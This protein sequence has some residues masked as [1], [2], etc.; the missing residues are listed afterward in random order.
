MWMG[1]RLPPIIRMTIGL[2]QAQLTEVHTILVVLL[3]VKKPPTCA[4]G[5]TVRRSPRA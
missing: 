3:C 5:I 2:P 4:H 1:V